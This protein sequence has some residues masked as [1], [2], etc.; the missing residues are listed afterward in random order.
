MTHVQQTNDHPKPF[1]KL[2]SSSTPSTLTFFP[3]SPLTMSS[4]SSHHRYSMRT[5]TPTPPSPSSWREKEEFALRQLLSARLTSRNMMEST[6]RKE[7]TTS[8]LRLLRA[9]SCGRIHI[10]SSVSEDR[11]RANMARGYPHKDKEWRLRPTATPQ[12][13]RHLIISGGISRDLPAL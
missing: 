12:Q 10:A 7:C 8:Y 11:L 3:K 1:T 13:N 9:P 4:S 5:F 2:N 6:S